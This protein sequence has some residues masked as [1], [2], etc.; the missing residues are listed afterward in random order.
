MLIIK[1]DA[2]EGCEK[3]ISDQFRKDPTLWTKDPLTRL[4]AVDNV[5]NRKCVYPTVNIAFLRNKLTNKKCKWVN[6]YDEQTYG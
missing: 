2:T 3:T 6:L 1:K 4:T 5:L